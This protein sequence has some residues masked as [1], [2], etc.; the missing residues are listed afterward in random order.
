[1]LHLSR[2]FQSVRKY[3]QCW[4]HLIDVKSEVI[5][6]LNSNKPIVALE[7]TII[8]HGMPY[9]HNLNTALQVED[10]VRKSVNKIDYLQLYE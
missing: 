1:M 10:V 6:A 7:S 8:T 4:K 3:S 2:Q 9:P 5:D